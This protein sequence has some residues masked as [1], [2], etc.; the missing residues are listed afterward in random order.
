MIIKITTTNS[1]CVEYILAYLD[2]LENIILAD[3]S[4][5]AKKNPEYKYEYDIAREE[6]I[7]IIRHGA[8]FILTTSEEEILR[9]RIS[10]SF[11]FYINNIRCPEY[12]KNELLTDISI[13][14]P[15]TFYDDDEEGLACYYFQHSGIV[16]YQ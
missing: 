1:D 11:M 13:S 7:E 5:K 14:F 12:I 10:N 4:Y 15:T 9:D 8:E 2:I 6:L 16:F 3:L